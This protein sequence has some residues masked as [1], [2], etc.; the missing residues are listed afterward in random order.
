MHSDREKASTDA[1]RSHESYGVDMPEDPD[2]HLSAAE[3]AEVVC[4]STTLSK[5]CTDPVEAHSLSF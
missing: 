4:Y 2:A 1:N 3:K 5:P